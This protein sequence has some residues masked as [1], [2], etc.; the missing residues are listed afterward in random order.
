MKVRYTIYLLMTAVF[1]CFFIS[2]GTGTKAGENAAKGAVKVAL[3][4]MG[5]KSDDAK[6]LAAALKEKL[7]ALAAQKGDITFV[8]A[9]DENSIPKDAQ[10]AVSAEISTTGNTIANT[11]V[12][13]VGDK[14]ED[15]SSK[16]LIG[17]ADA[18]ASQMM[19]M[20]RAQMGSLPTPP[21]THPSKP[22]NVEPVKPQPVPVSSP[23]PAATDTPP[24]SSTPAITVTP[25][26]PV[27]APSQP[28]A[29]TAAETPPAAAATPPS[30]KQITIK[31]TGAGVGTIIQ[32]RVANAKKVAEIMAKRDA[33]ERALGSKVDLL[34]A[35]EADRREI[36][37][38]TNGF[39]K[40][41]KVLYEQQKGNYYIM[42]IEAEILIPEDLLKKFAPPPQA[43][44]TG[45]PPA[46]QP[47]P[48]G[49]INWGDGYLTA[50]GTGKPTA[51]DEQ[52]AEAAK[53]AARVDAYAVA[54]EMINGVNYDPDLGIGDV[55]KDK[56]NQNTEYKIVGTV[57]GAEVIKT[58]KVGADFQTTIQVPLWGLKGVSIAFN[59]LYSKM[60]AP[61]KQEKQPGGEEQPVGKPYTGLIIDARGT[62]LKPAM[63][64]VI[65]DESG[66]VIYAAGM[67]T[68]ESIVRRGVAAYAVGDA[69]EKKQ[70]MIFGPNPLRINA[71]VVTAPKRIEVAELG[72]SSWS[73]LFSMNTILPAPWLF[74]GAEAKVIIRQGNAPANVK[75]SS[76]G[77]AKNAK[78][79]VSNKSAQ[80]IS[81]S[82]KKNNY[83]AEGRAVII[84]DSMVGATEGK[85]HIDRDGKMAAR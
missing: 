27:V 82:A 46:V 4:P 38:A 10:L 36:V 52:A 16:M 33:A 73:N 69:S 34:A 13:K 26:S 66:A 65:V 75:A 7:I 12:F 60:S 43:E 58:E 28:A 23:Q 44:S 37:A 64:P 42:Q 55:L 79:V 25:V 3:L 57:Q 78:V 80:L 2:G 19:E 41:W 50:T 81:E 15:R 20:I 9:A 61:P 47:F 24:P 63:F 54:L 84:I 30:G 29:P 31:V 35:P 85:N 18:L 17:P 40:S 14:P 74:I 70:G 83:L 77:G 71:M 72:E 56:K 76:S 5:A 39:I 8:D 45:L 53:R 6:Q 59:D 32:G 49:R 48:K 67:V 22:A 68:P 11:K 21:P 62:G 1:F 51:D